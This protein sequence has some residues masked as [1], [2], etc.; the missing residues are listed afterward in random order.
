METRLNAAALSADASR[1]TQAREKKLL[2]SCQQFASI[3][4]SYMMKTMREGSAGGDEQGFASGVYQDMF[5]DQVAKVVA[6]SNSLGLG[7][8]LYTQL[9]RSLETKSHPAAAAGVPKKG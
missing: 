2:N 9:E 5:S 7:K 3:Y 6:R 1:E 8:M 4:V